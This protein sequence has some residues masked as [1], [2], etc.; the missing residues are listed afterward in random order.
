MEKSLSAEKL[1]Q[2]ECIRE[3]AAPEWINTWINEY[4]SESLSDSLGCFTCIHAVLAF[5]V[6]VIHKQLYEAPNLDGFKLQRSALCQ[7]QHIHTLLKHIERPKACKP[8]AIGTLRQQLPVLDKQLQLQVTVYLLLINREML[9]P[10]S[11]S[12][13]PTLFHN[14]PSVSF[15]GHRS[16][17]WLHI[18]TETQQKPIRACT[19]LLVIITTE[20][21]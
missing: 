19:Q 5:T 6:Q 10:Q 16:H 20:C 14:L 21:S 7:S 4:V 3:H 12:F 9:G 13:L 11:L 15:S 2:V 18:N 1:R 8:T 17:S